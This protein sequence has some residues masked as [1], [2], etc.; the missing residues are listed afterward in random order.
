IYLRHT[1][2]EFS[3]KKVMLLVQLSGCFINSLLFC[4]I[5]PFPLYPHK[6]FMFTGPF[7]IFGVQTFS[8]LFVVWCGN[9]SFLSCVAITN[10]FNHYIETMEQFKQKN[11]FFEVF[12]NLSIPRRMIFYCL[13]VLVI[14]LIVSATIFFSI[15][16][17][18]L[19]VDGIF[20]YL[21]EN[22]AMINLRSKYGTLE[23]C[24]IA[25]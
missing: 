9:L 6:V 11:I 2:E 8:I 22:Y 10:S 25:K 15:D 7:R 4:L 16:V 19:L 21:R 3:S 13:F 1:P 17:D 14:V 12:R 5:Q 23:V 18:P 20:N 24:Y